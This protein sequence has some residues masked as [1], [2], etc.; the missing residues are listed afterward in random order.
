ML[1]EIRKQ[2]LLKINELLKNFKDLPPPLKTDKY[3]TYLITTRSLLSPVIKEISIPHNKIGKVIG[4]K[5][6]ILKQIEKD[7]QCK[8]TIKD[9]KCTIE[10]DKAEEVVKYIQEIISVKKKDF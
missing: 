8:L 9:D 3:K 4:Q 6:C 2:R 1:Q 10:G 7:Y 5:G